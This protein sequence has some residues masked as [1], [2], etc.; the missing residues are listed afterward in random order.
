MRN[1]RYLSV[2][3]VPFN[4]FGA[5]S[6]MGD[7]GRR[8]MELVRRSMELLCCPSVE[9]FQLARPSLKKCDARKARFG[10]TWGPI[11]MVNMSHMVTPTCLYSN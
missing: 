5:G 10:A 4:S 3:L 1:S 8:S 6:I 11:R 7:H 2:S 9:R